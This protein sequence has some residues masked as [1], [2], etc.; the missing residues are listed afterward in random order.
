MYFK[1]TFEKAVINMDRNDFVTHYTKSI[2]LKKKIAK[3]H[4]FKSGHSH[5]K[6]IFLNMK[7]STNLNVLSFSKFIQIILLR[8]PSVQNFLCFF[9]IC[10]EM[11]TKQ[12]NCITKM[13]KFKRN[14]KWTKELCVYFIFYFLDKSFRFILFTNNNK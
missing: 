4:T 9:C 10:F 14:L 8:L 7:I 5:Q 13:T 6:Q 1:Q 11:W 2:T 12:I 3:N